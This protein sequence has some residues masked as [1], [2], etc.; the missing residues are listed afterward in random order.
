MPSLGLANNITSKPEHRQLMPTDI[1]YF[2]TGAGAFLGNTVNAV[3]LVT[4]KRL[5]VRATA[6]EGYT[7]RT[8]SVTPGVTYTFSIQFNHQG[9]TPQSTGLLQLG[10][11]DGGVDLIDEGFAGSTN[12]YSTTI[13]PTG[14]VIYL[15]LVTVTNTKYCYW[16]N[17]TLEET[18]VY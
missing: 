8:F 10:N 18:V 17:V 12:N 1:E 2:N 3:N 11:T 7:H 16:D 4:G 13:I 5:S 9:G 14:S 6:T 15:R